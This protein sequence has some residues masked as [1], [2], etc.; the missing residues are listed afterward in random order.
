[1]IFEGRSKRAFNS[2]SRDHSC[3]EDYEPKLER[4]LVLSTPSLGITEQV[5]CWFQ[6]V[7]SSRLSTPSLGITWLISIWRPNPPYELSTPSLG[8]TRAE[9]RDQ[10][11]HS[12]N[13]LSTPSLGITVGIEY[14]ADGATPTFNSLSR[15]H[16]PVTLV[17]KFYE[18]LN[19]TFNSLSRDHT[20]TISPVDEARKNFP[21]N[22]LSR[23]H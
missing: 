22:S 1:M 18:L 10:G 19:L 15:D 7:C 6:M 21:F 2:L 14:A 12:I 11:H 16:D 13:E 8:I 9:L 4:G 5:S 20:T 23:D 3:V 17:E